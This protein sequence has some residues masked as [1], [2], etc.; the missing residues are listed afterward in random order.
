V[1]DVDTEIVNGF[2][3]RAGVE[4]ETLDRNWFVFAI[5]FEDITPLETVVLVLV[6]VAAVNRNQVVVVAGSAN[7]VEDIRPLEVVV[8]VF[9]DIRPLEVGVLV[10]VTVDRSQVVFVAVDLVLDTLVEILAVNVNSKET[11]SRLMV[12]GIVVAE[13]VLFLVIAFHTHVRIIVVAVASSF[14]ESAIVVS[15]FVLELLLPLV[16]GYNL[17][18]KWVL[19]GSLV[20]LDQ[21]V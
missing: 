18:G 20:D 6:T 15:E 4:T 9:E 5:V 13:V 12:V 17:P 21:C 7:S 10:L 1:A 16:V 14:Q 3:D 8:L 2:E 11:V 19:H